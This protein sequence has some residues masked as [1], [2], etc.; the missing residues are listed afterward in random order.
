MGGARSEG[1]APLRI[2]DLWCGAGGFGS[3]WNT[4]EGPAEGAEVV[5]LTA[6]RAGLEGDYV[7]SETANAATQLAPGRVL[8]IIADRGHRSRALRAARRAGLVVIDRVLTVSP[9]PESTHLVPLDP[10]A[11]RHAGTRHLGLSPKVSAVM[12]QL[13][14]TELGRRLLT[15]M[16]NGCAI[17]ATRPPSSERF[18]RLEAIDGIGVATSTV[19]ISPRTDARVAVAMRFPYGSRDPDLAVKIAL[20]Q[21]GLDRLQREREALL[22]YGRTAAQAGAAVPFPRHAPSGAVLASDALRGQPASALMAH[23]PDRRGD[24]I[25][26][27]ASWLLAWNRATLGS[28]AATEEVVE[29][30]LLDPLKRILAAKP[31]TVQYADSV[32]RLADR[33]VGSPVATVVVHNDLTM[34]NVLLD[35]G[36]IGIVDWE[37]ADGAGPPLLDLWY[38]LAD[39]VSRSWRIGHT[40]AVKLLVARSPSIPNMLSDLPGAHASSLG[41]SDDQVRLG[42]HACWLGHADDEVQRDAPGTFLDLVEAI[43]ADELW[44]AGI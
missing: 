32:R 10:A 17:V 6:G 39:G 21:P 28:T 18:G 27:V 4:E 43:A 33:L 5:V 13:C 31:S 22:A 35:A 36:N 15:R 24:V 2:L 7:D 44:W 14:R 11:V 25:G 30:W 1:R 29:R 9:W 8:W 19:T 16:A 37:A 41:L 40:S 38:M 20:D 26:A 42:F 34:S 23:S 12:A 3:E